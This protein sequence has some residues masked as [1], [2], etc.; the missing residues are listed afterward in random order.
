MK[1]VIVSDTHG[2][3]GIE[4]PDGDLLIHAGDFSGRGT[5]K[6]LIRFNA[7]MGRLPHS[8]KLVIPGNHDLFVEKDPDLARVIA[9][10]FRFLIDEEI[11]IN[12]IRIFGSPWTPQFGPWAYMRDPC[13]M[14]EV[15]ERLPSGLDILVT[16][17][18]PHGVLD[19]VISYEEKSGK[20]GIGH[21]GCVSLFNRVMEIKPK[22]H[23]FGHIHEGYGE[24]EMYGTKFINASICTRWHK[25]TN[26]PIV[27]EIESV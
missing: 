1:I 22:H 25:P 5:E 8:N 18:P 3:E 19:E 6:D 7:W 16:H 12:G 9:T 21:A 2:F 13:Q 26:P 14:K 17:G 11:S 15:W 27:L 24:L 20:T 23:L 10:N 4:V